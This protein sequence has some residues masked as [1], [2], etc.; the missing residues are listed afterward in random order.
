MSNKSEIST[1]V[2]VL[3]GSNYGTWHKSMKVYLMSLGLWGHVS[4]SIQM[5]IAPRNPALDRNGNAVIAVQSDID[6][7]TTA[8]DAYSI[9]F[10]AWS[11]DDEKALGAILL[12]LNNAIKEDVISKNYAD[13]VWAYLAMCYGQATP[14]Q[15]LQDFKEA[16]SIRIKA[17][18]NPSIALDRM[19]TA[20]QRLNN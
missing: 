19:S 5:P 2:P 18:Q 8:M 6:A 1:L 20:F 17:D 7:Y 10:P 14:S 4:G 12:R 13:N 9:S 16:M 3:D 11:K 15:I